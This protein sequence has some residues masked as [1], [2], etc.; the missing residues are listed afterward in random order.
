M[1]M[2]YNIQDDCYAGCEKKKENYTRHCITAITLAEQALK[3][4]KVLAEP[5]LKIAN[6]LAAKI[7]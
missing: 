2:I 4:I 6:N 1:T 3:L 5:L 7:N